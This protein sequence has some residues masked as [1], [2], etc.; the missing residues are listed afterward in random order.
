VVAMACS[1]SSS[2][3]SKM[4]AKMSANWNICSMRSS[5]AVVGSGA[6]A[7]A[8]VTGRIVLTVSTVVLGKRGSFAPR[9]AF[10]LDLIDINLGN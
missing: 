1:C 3:A 10:G 6:R 2:S 7:P 9:T 5:G 8:V 4:E